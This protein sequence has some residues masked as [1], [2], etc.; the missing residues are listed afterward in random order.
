M[1]RQASRSIV[2]SSPGWRGRGAVAPEVE[3]NPLAKEAN[4]LEIAN[5]H[6]QTIQKDMRQVRRDNALSPDEKRAKLDGLF[7]ERN[8][9]L[10]RSVEE[11]KASIAGRPTA[12]PAA[13]P[14]GFQFV[15]TAK[16]N[17]QPVYQ[18]PSG[19]LYT[20]D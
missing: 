5:K 11:A 1:P 19:K 18:A 9:L 12:Q 8:D 17:G 14:P 15:G 6:L 10:K 13:L 3:R 7:V 4:P 16:D 20:I 2:K